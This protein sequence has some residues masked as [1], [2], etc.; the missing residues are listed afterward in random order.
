METEPLVPSL[1]NIY[2]KAEDV[3]AKVAHSLTANTTVIQTLLQSIQSLDKKSLDT[4]GGNAEL[5]EKIQQANLQI[6]ENKR[7]MTDILKMLNDF[8]VGIETIFRDN[9]VDQDSQMYLAKLIQEKFQVLHLQNEIYRK[10]KDAEEEAT[11]ENTDKYQ[12]VNKKVNELGKK[13]Q[14][15]LASLPENSND[16]LIEA[17][18]QMT[19]IQFDYLLSINQE[20]QKQYTAL[21]ARDALSEFSVPIV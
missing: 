16:V 15:T 7:S 17:A 10:L 11:R 20:I 13:Y 12:A 5:Q 1:Q 2:D 8:I 9:Y 18:R 4:L 19:Q 6:I 14:E 3:H 21:I